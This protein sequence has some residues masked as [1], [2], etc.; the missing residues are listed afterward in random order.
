MNKLIGPAGGVET[1]LMKKCHRLRA[2][3]KSA[4][5][6]LLYGPPGTGKTDLA[7]RVARDL[8]GHEMG[9]ESINGANVT[10]EVVREWQSTMRTATLWSDWRVLVINEGDRISQ[11]AQVI[12]LTLLDELPPCRAVVVTSNQS[13]DEMVERFQSRMQQ[14]EVGPPGLAEISEFLQRMNVPE[15]QADAIAIG[16]KGNVRSAILD[17]E[18]YLDCAA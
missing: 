4:L 17:A 14:F 5:R 3:G 7:N 15:A 10:A 13:L 2:E 9:I 8:A 1:I 16:A 18:S 6:L 12:M 11:Q